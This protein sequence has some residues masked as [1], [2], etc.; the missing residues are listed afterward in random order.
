MVQRLPNWL[1]F[2][3]LILIPF[4]VILMIDPTPGSIT[5]ATVIF[6]VA[7]ITDYVD[8]IIARRYG[9]VSD[10]GKL[11]DPMADKILVMA[12][13]V[14]I[15][16]QKWVPGWMVVA[17]LAREIWV[18]G[19]RGVAASQGTVV[20]ASGSGKFKSGLQM[21]AIVFLLQQG[22]GLQ[23]A[24][25]M[26]TCHQFGIFLL[27]ISLAFSYWGATEYTL[28]ILYPAPAAPKVGPGEAR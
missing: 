4:F 22:G 24:G 13:L 21:V 6:I 2:L 18:T 7:A 23:L 20:A 10:F 12:A 11:L 15:A 1:T 16:S 27:L 5:A 17:V 19:L 26:V 9:A 28:H 3:R 25:H 8:G 14:M